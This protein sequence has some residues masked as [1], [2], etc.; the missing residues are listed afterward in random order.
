MK[1]LIPK[2]YK[3]DRGFFLESFNQQSFGHTFV[4]DNHSRS[5]QYVLRGLHYQL[6][7]PQGKLVRAIKGSVLDVAV[8]I[9]KS[10]PT[11][12]KYHAEILSAENFKQMWIPPGFAHGFVVLTTKAE[13]LYKT[14]EYWFKEHDR[15][16]KWNDPELNINWAIAKPPILSAKDEE[17]PYLRDAEV[18][19]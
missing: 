12:G 18:F 8:D 17:A 1:F 10:S 3:D 6:V 13:V 15:S 5:S 16:I 11:F 14:T 4:Q 19:D 7:K 9:R 2:I